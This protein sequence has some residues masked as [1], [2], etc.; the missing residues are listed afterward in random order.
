MSTSNQTKYIR[1]ED[2]RVLWIPAAQLAMWEALGWKRITRAAYRAAR[3]KLAKGGESGK[4]K[5]ITARMA[6]P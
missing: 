6:L 3:K 1:A 5:T 2:G 4:S